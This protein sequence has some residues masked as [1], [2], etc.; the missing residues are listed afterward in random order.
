MFYKNI[1]VINLIEKSYFQ[2]QKIHKES[3]YLTIGYH[4]SS[5]HLKRLED[6]FVQAVNFLITRKALILN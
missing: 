4:G 3:K 1:F 6:G 2:K 5:S